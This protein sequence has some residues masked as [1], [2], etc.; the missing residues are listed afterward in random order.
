LFVSD[1]PIPDKF[2]WTP[3]EGS[4]DGEAADAF[5]QERW[6]F[7]KRELNRYRCKVTHSIDNYNEGTYYK[8][9][10]NKASYYEDSYNE[11]SYNK[12]TFTEDSYSKGTYNKDNCTEN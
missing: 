9:I 10:C 7:L 1:P 8:D 6:S 11:G 3:V 5:S 4:F 12:V 2:I